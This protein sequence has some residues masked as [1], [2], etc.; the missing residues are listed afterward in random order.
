MADDQHLVDF[1]A[2]SRLNSMPKLVQTRFNFVGI[3]TA[4][5]RGVGV[6]LH[7]IIGEGLVIQ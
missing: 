7:Q 4:L 3:R 5:G 1:L 6:V 2:Q